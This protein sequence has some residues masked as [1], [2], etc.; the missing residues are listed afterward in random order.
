MPVNETEERRF[1][2]HAVFET[3][4]KLHRVKGLAP[5]PSIRALFQSGASVFPGSGIRK[6][7]HIQICVRDISIIEGC[8]LVTP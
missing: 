6:W 7:D 1:L 5:F 2:D 4:H 3:L 8:F